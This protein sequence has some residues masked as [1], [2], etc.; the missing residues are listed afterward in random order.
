MQSDGNSFFG[1]VVLASFDMASR[2]KHNILN[3]VY[4]NKYARIIFKMILILYKIIRKC[5]LTQQ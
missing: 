2:D 1:D 4:K 5:L 3:Q